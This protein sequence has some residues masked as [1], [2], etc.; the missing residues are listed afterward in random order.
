MKKE[1]DIKQNNQ[2]INKLIEKI[3]EKRREERSAIEKDGIIDPKIKKILED[4]I[5]KCLEIYS[6]EFPRV[7]VPRKGY[8]YFS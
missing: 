6:L 2:Q 1:N 8:G 7:Q 4:E 3:V 5:H